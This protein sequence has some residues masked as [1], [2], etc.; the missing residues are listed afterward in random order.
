MTDRD[1]LQRMIARI[2]KEW[3]SSLTPSAPGREGRQH[4]GE[5]RR[6]R[7]SLTTE[8]GGGAKHDTLLNQWQ[9]NSRGQ[10]RSQTDTASEEVVRKTAER[11]S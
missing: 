4:G 6:L 7:S 11:A 8:D 9:E 3:R 2:G 1:F 5:S 10:W